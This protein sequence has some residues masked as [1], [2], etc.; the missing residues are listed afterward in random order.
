MN[1]P[2]CTLAECGG[3]LRGR[4]VST[5]V[6]YLDHY[7]EAP[8]ADGRT[9]YTVVGERRWAAS[10]GTDLRAILDNFVSVG[11]AANIS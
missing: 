8:G 6:F 11:T 3:I 1:F 10:E 9:S 5:D 2:G 7:D 4:K